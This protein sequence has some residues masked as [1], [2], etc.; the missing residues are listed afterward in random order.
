MWFGLKGNE[1]RIYKL[2]KSEYEYIRTVESS[3]PNEAIAP[4]YNT[5]REAAQPPVVDPEQLA[6]FDPTKIKAGG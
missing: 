2:E 4:Y 6:G 3:D 1:W 5:V